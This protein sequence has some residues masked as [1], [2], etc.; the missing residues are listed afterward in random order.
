MLELF[1][2]PPSLIESATAYAFPYQNIKQ[3]LLRLGNK[4]FA[5][6]ENNKCDKGL[7]WLLRQN[8]GNRKEETNKENVTNFINSM[9]APFSSQQIDR[10]IN[11][12]LTLYG[13]LG[14]ISNE[15]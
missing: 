13:N 1:E 8:A 5:T 14:G 6:L 15:K 12:L 7:A 11:S 10:L 4:G 2:E 3:I 9:F